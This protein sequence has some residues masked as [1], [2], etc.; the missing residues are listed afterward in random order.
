VGLGVAGGIVDTGEDVMAAANREVVEETGWQ[1]N[2]L[3]HL[4][5]FQPIPGMVNTPHALFMSDGAEKV[6]EP[7]N[8]E[9]AAVVD[10]VPMAD[11]LELARQGEI[12][13]SGS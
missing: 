3:L 12:L 5:T 10:W 1:P 8:A 6:G 2:Q 13:G 4:L 9:E 7:T 11:V